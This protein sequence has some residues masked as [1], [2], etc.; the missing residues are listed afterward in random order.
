M[1]IPCHMAIFNQSALFKFGVHRYIKKFMTSAP[2]NKVPTAGKAQ[3]KKRFYCDL[4]FESLYLDKCHSIQ[5]R[6]NST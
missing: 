4:M 1:D 6:T 3:M 5:C 2:E